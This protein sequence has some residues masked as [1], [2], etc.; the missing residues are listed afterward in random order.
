MCRS[1]GDPD[2]STNKRKEHA[3]QTAALADTPGGS[4]EA[5]CHQSRR[6]L[7][8]KTFSSLITAVGRTKKKDSICSRRHHLIQETRLPS[9]RAIWRATEP[10]FQ[11]GASSTSF[12]VYFHHDGTDIKPLARHLTLGQLQVLCGSA[13]III[14]TCIVTA[15]NSSGREP[16]MEPLCQTSILSL[17]RLFGGNGYGAF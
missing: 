7:M 3:V 9:K 6:R 1:S 4:A 16:A 14:M 8:V 15:I 2:D 17:H 5:A 13:E 11:R 10:S 12:T